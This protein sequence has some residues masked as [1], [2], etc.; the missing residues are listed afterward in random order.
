MAMVQRLVFLIDAEQVFR[1]TSCP[2]FE[3]DG[4]AA[5]SE[6]SAENFVRVKPVREPGLVAARIIAPMTAVAMAMATEPTNM[7]TRHPAFGLSQSRDEP[8]AQTMIAM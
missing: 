4:M 5:G 3:A 8:V 6:E 2:G 7:I 1:Q